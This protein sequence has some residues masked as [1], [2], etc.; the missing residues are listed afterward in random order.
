M[1]VPAPRSVHA[2]LIIN[3]V[4]YDVYALTEQIDEKFIAYN[5]KDTVGNL[6][7]EIWPI[8]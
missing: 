6:Y 7:K 8:N 2:R 1:D 3:G 4:Y 5:Y